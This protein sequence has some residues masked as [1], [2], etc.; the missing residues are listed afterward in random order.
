[1]RSVMTIALSSCA[2]L[3][4]AGPAAAAAPAAYSVVVESRTATTITVTALIK[5]DE[6]VTSHFEYGPTTAYGT[7]TPEASPAPDGDGWYR[8]RQTISGLSS[9]TQYRVRVVATNGSGTVPGPDSAASTETVDTDGDGH[10]DH[11]DACPTV[12]HPAGCPPADAD[13]DGTA[14]SADMCPTLHGVGGQYLGCP[15][16][17]TPTFRT[18][19]VQITPQGVQFKASGNLAGNN[20]Y[21]RFEISRFEDFLPRGDVDGS[22]KT[23][24]KQKTGVKDIDG[25]DQHESNFYF[26]PLDPREG[27]YRD[28]EVTC[29]SDPKVED[30]SVMSPGRKLYVRA[31][32][33]TGQQDL[34]GG[35]QSFVM[36]GGGGGGGGTSPAEVSALSAALTPSGKAAKLDQILKKGGYTAP[37]KCPSAGAAAV[38]WST[39]VKGKT[40]VVASGAASCKET[41]GTSR[42]V[43]TSAAS[44]S[45]L[46]I[47]LTKKGKALLKKAKSAKLTTQTSFTPKGG[48]KVSVNGNLTLKR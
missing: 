42:K 38:T 36:P 7:S 17:G 30:T 13:G 44:G 25:R 34:S 27:W 46:K 5:S 18:D 9:G 22:G 2:L 32:L 1:M 24:C 20:Q 15:P 43:I 48:K 41:G 4:M 12:P 31:V 3:L 8:A 35:V 37:L 45:S 14:D 40:V 47:A 23:S 21:V 11:T 39:K 29:L 10:P 33:G 16:P 19:P 26:Y 6:P 28:G